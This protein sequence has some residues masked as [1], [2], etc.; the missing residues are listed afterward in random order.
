MRR[1]ENQGRTRARC[2]R[3]IM[4]QRRGR[5]GIVG[6]CV[7]ACAQ[8]GWGASALARGT[9]PSRAWASREK[10]ERRATQSEL[11]RAFVELTSV[12]VSHIDEE[13]FQRF[14]RSTISRIGK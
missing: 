4:H 11:M 1:V 7:C 3:G 5:A 14:A 9:E 6:A 12:K 13:A 10:R 2:A 8:A